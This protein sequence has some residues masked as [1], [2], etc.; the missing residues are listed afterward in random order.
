MVDDAEGSIN[1]NDD[2]IIH[3]PP[4]S[5]SE[6]VVEASEPLGE[7]AANDGGSF[8]RSEDEL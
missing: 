7:G 5:V 3:H 2:D 8:E 6:M 4:P 1:N